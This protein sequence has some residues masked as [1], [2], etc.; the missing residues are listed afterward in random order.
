M[1]PLILPTAILLGLAPLLS[2][3]VA[4]ELLAKGFERPVWAGAPVSAKGKLWVMEQAGTVWIVDLKTGE[5]SKKPFLEIT[6]I[7]TRK[8]NEQ[9]LLGLA[10]A[11]DFRKSGRSSASI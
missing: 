7:V 3:G 2:A 6:D 5:R 1:K 11:P 8:S 4:S 9:G 10:F